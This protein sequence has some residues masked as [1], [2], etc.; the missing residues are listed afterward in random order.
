MSSSKYDSEL[1]WRAAANLLQPTDE[2]K[3]DADTLSAD[4]VAPQ[5]DGAR[6][7]TCLTRREAEVAGLIAH[8]YSNREIADQLHLSEK[9]VRNYVSHILNKLEL[10]NR[11][12]VAVWM[13]DSGIR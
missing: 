11:T 7:A 5:L 8:G 3:T 2:E 12:Q 9:T 6:E 10:S 1:K 13:R 4:L